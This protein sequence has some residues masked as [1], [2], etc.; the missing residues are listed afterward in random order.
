MLVPTRGREK[1]ARI[2]YNR[3]VGDGHDGFLG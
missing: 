1:V 3:V 2:V